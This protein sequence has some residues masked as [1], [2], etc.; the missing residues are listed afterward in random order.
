ME[1]GSSALAEASRA[2]QYTKENLKSQKSKSASKKGYQKNISI[3]QETS[4]SATKKRIWWKTPILFR[5]IQDAVDAVGYPWSPTAIDKYLK[6]KDWNTFRF[7]HR[8]RIDDWRDSRYSNKFI[9]KAS[10]LESVK[11]GYQKPPSITR[12]GILVSAV[13][14]ILNF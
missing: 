12:S 4:T 14:V 3:T 11:R 7:F 8:Q 6:K 9:W 5:Q 2:T 13:R 10:V 1:L